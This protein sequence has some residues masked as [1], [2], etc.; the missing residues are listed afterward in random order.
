MEGDTIMSEKRHY[1]CPQCGKVLTVYV[2][3]SVPPTCTNPEKHTSLTVEM[4]EKK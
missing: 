2:K 3:P 1:E 4:V